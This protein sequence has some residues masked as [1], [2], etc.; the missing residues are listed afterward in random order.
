[1]K[2]SYQSFLYLL[3]FS[4]CFST[5]NAQSLEDE[6][7]INKRFVA[8]QFSAHCVNQY[9]LPPSVE[10]I[11][12]DIQEDDLGYTHYTYLEYYNGICVEDG[13]LKVHVKG[14]EISN[15]SGNVVELGRVQ[16]GKIAEVE[17]ISAAEKHVKGE[18]LRKQVD[19]EYEPITERVIVKL[20]NEAIEAFKVDVYFVLPLIRKDVYVSAASGEVILIKDKIHTADAIGTA[21][22]KY[23]G[24]QQIV[25]DS[26]AADTFR[27]RET[28]RGGGIETFNMQQ[29][30]F[31][32][33]DFIDHDNSWNN[34]NGNQDEVATDAHW[35]AEMFYDYFDVNHGRNSFDD[36]G[37]KLITNVHYGVNYGN[38]FWDGSTVSLGDGDGAT[39]GPLAT[40]DIIAHEF[41][42][43]IIETTANLNFSYESGALSESFADIFATA[44]EF[45][46]KPSS[47]NWTIKEDA[48]LSGG[49][50]H[51][52]ASP[53]TYGQPDTYLG[54]N[55]ASGGADNGGVHTNNGVQNYWFYLL[56]M[57]GS[58][59]NDNGDS[60]TVT[61]IGMDEALAIT[62]RALIFYH[63]SSSQYADARNYSIQAAEDLF[64]PCTAEV[65]AVTNAWYAVGVGAE[66]SSAPAVAGFISDITYACNLPATVTFID[67]STNA[68]NYEWHFGDATTS[69]LA[70]VAHTY[71]TAGTYTVSQVVSGIGCSVGNDTLT[72][73]NYITVVNGGGPIL[74]ACSPSTANLSANFGITNVTFN[75][76]NHT[77]GYSNGED[78]MDNTC[79]VQTT[80]DAGG[81]YPLSISTGNEY[82]Y[83]W[84]DYNNDGNFS[85]SEQEYAATNRS[86]I[87]LATITIPGG[88]ILNTP[89][90]M[91]VASS[92]NTLTADACT[93]STW[94]QYEDF[95]VLIVPNTNPPVAD[96]IANVTTINV[97]SGVNFVDAS[98]GAPSSW[99]WEFAGANQAGSTAQNP[100]NITYNSVGSYEVKLVVTNS[101]GVDSVTKYNYINVVNSVDLCSATATTSAAN[102]T[103]FDSGGP[104]SNY[105]DNENCTFLIDPGC[106]TPITLS[107]TSFDVENGWDFVNVYDGSSQS[108]TLLLQATGSSIPSSVVANSG[109]MFIV[110]SSDGSVT[111]PGFEATWSSAAGGA[112]P[113]AGFSV[114]DT[115]PAFNTALT[116]TDLTSNAPN[117]WQWDFGDGNSSA[118]ENPV[119]AYSSSGSFTVTL[120]ATNCNSSDTT[121]LSLTVSTPPI[122]TYTPNTISDTLMC[123][124]SVA[125]PIT[126]YNSGMG[127]LSVIHD[128]LVSQSG[129]AFFDGFESGNLGAWADQ[130][131]A[132]TKQVVSSASATGA[133]SL[134]MQGGGFNFFDGLMHTFTSS[135]PTQISFK[136]MSPSTNSFGCMVTFGD[137]NTISNS[138][139]GSFYIDFSGSINFFGGSGV[140]HSFSPNQWFVIEYRNI[141][142][143]NSTFDFYV[144]GVLVQA[145]VFFA[146]IGLTSIDRV[147]LSGWSG[148]TTSYFD[149]ISVG[150]LP[151]LS[152]LTLDEDTA[153]VATGDSAVYMAMINSTG[154]SAGNYTVDLNFE[155]NDTANPIVIIPVNLNIVGHPDVSFSQNC[156]SV[157]TTFI[158]GTSSEPIVI[159][160]SGCDTLRV[161][162]N[163]SITGLFE[164]DSINFVVPPYDSIVLNILFTAAAIQSYQD[165]ITLSDNAGGSQICVNGVGAGSPS[166]II[167][168]MGFT[169][170]LDA[171]GDSTTV[172]MTVYNIGASALDFE[173]V[174][175]AS[176]NNDFYDGFESA[177]ITSWVDQG[178][179]YT[180]QVTNSESAAG[181][182]SLE[183]SGGNNNLLDGLMHTF[184]SAT[185]SELSFR[186]K[187][188]STSDFGCIITIGDSNT[189]TSNGLG[190]FY[191]DFSGF[192]TFSGTGIANTTYVPGQWHTIE[193]KNIDYTNKMLDFYVDG[194]LVQAALQFSD[195]GLTSLDRIYVSGYG[196]STSAFIDEIVIG[197]AASNWMAASPGTG[198]V[199]VSDSMQVDLTFNSTGLAGGQYISD[200]IV[201]TNDPVNAQ[202]F[203]P[204]TL[205]VSSD[206]C[207]EYSYTMS[208]CNGDV[209]FIDETANNPTTWLWDFGDG[210]SATIQNPTHNYAAVATYTVQLIVCNGSGCDT[211]VQQVVVN[212]I[213]GPVAAICSPVT[214]NN[215]CGIGITNV[216]FNTINNTTNDGIDGYVDYTC[217]QSTMVYEGQTYL[218][219]VVTGTSLQENCMAWID[220]NNNGDLETSEE[221][222]N[223][224]SQ[225]TNHSIS[226]T[227]PMGAVQNTP[228]R[229]R[230]GSD[231]DSMGLSCDNITY[232]QYEDYSVT[233]VPNNVPPIAIFSTIITD[234]CLGQVFFTDQSYNSPTSWQWDFGDGNSSAVQSPVHTYNAAGVYSVSLIAINAFGADTINSDVI[235]NTMDAGF[236]Y[237]GNIVVGGTVDF[238]S[239]SSGAI[240]WNWDFDNG[241]NSS[242]EDPSMVYSASGVYNVTLTAINGFGCSGSSVQ[243][244]TITNPVPPTA[245]FSSSLLDIC[246]GEYQFN[247]MSTG[248]P[249][250]W[251]WSFGDGNTSTNQNPT[252]TYSSA[253]AY[254]VS[255]TAANAQGSDISTQVVT[256]SLPNLS[257]TTSGNLEVGN[258]IAFTG[259]ATGNVTMWLW[260]FGDGFSATI[261]NP[262][263]VYSTA[264]TYIVTLQITDD[265]N[266]QTLTADTLEII[267]VDGINYL[268]KDAIFDVFPNPNKG[269]FTIEYLGFNDKKVKLEILNTLGQSIINEK[270]E[271]DGIWSKPINLSTEGTGVYYIRLTS[272][273]K[274]LTKRVIIH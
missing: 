250:S 190:L 179:S 27:L 67:Q 71:T 232:G 44:V 146:N 80:V 214:V 199:V 72:Y 193:Y 139:I 17:A 222:L 23:S 58:G 266:C 28:A 264:G 64:G 134:E 183:I 147:Y 19:L 130:G 62:Y 8:S 170:N 208:N 257:L 162:S 205:N 203:V 21:T 15:I 252:Y 75:G 60:Y 54:I 175:G 231:F 94:G 53:N 201:N 81:V 73:I 144:D 211:T 24:P 234:P 269:M 235:I 221:V 106:T 111:Q 42:H 228:L 209:D 185:P 26:I 66:Y 98:A 236:T 160:N 254:T 255:L 218:L 138:G 41:T 151:S 125:V 57:G 216:S 96:F 119:Y 241:M 192:L 180:K 105:S 68:V 178:G 247:D 202:V 123:G 40:V 194:L 265:N 113:I 200:L 84:I 242:L 25:T 267:L 237:S 158:G 93:P 168:P 206:P 49:A 55:W 262:V 219:D 251:Q 129:G 47:A 48:H 140:I 270:Y 38:A 156:T 128:L 152:W 263:Y 166:V 261:Q 268:D 243:P 3:F 95:T 124:D 274:T 45:Y 230:I 50:D 39:Y 16:S 10:F 148:G 99:D 195:F 223:S 126:F 56:S 77:S 63:T 29:G 92:F 225:L 136:V 272:N 103:L 90:R 137:V 226:V 173:I 229:M 76:I 227:I 165:T 30:F 244:I 150:E 176:S 149:D 115:T 197:E 52:L 87:H 46:A 171:C 132:Y 35:A 213:G 89:L 161:S 273:G 36:A 6:Q 181:N 5:I 112:N 18:I 85:A 20:G 238:S 69:N 259:A 7:D 74:A 256:I 2:V 167:N 108:G 196:A 118:D 141:D 248:S 43:G 240:S 224:I 184:P 32:S 169:V 61:G 121:S 86:N 174:N 12:K 1:M 245:I 182:Y 101:F 212:N 91:R 33:V 204:C 117:Q 11:I 82:A 186:V 191:I 107:F 22:T 13:I 172:P 110:F 210:S 14:K 188:T 159:Y 198:T 83:M 154:F 88:T 31:G 153:D 109:Q 239:N 70:N 4:F 120:I 249:T 133:Y 215:C 260:N 142:Y 100:S 104:T 9:N 189:P 79:S 164:L 65:E 207:G 116:F 145:S 253:G 102:G 246:T 163:S 37:A 157:D 233:I 122:L 51:S 143:V 114:T 34:V 59:T 155:T 271:V 187:S 217:S 127:N 135:N 78:Y 177:N 220:F 258:P 97:G 131:G